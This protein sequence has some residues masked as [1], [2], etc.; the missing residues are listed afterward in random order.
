VLNCYLTAI[1]A[2]IRTQVELTCI[3]RTVSSDCSG[4]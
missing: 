4:S 3:R 2:V 1:S